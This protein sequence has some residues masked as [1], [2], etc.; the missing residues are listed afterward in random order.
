MTFIFPIHTTFQFLTIKRMVERMIQ[1]RILLFCLIAL[2]VSACSSFGPERISPDRF[3]YNDAIASSSN[4]QMLLNIVRLRYEDV[5]VFLTVSSV[6]TQYVY[7]SNA[8]VSGAAGLD[9]IIGSSVGGNAGIRYI[10]RPTITYSPLSGDDFAKQLLT[11]IPSDLIFSLIQSGWPAKELL[12][13]SLQRINSVVNTGDNSVAK[14]TD[15]TQQQFMRVIQLIIELGKRG[16][17]EVQRQNQNDN[18][19]PFL[20]FD[21]TDDAD[22]LRLIAEFKQIL[23]LDPERTRFQV[24]TRVVQRKPEEVTIR[25]RSMLTLMGFLAHG[26]AIPPA[27]AEI[28]TLPTQPTGSDN[29]RQTIPSPLQIHASVERPSDAFVSIRYQGHWFSIDR[30]DHA[31]KQAFGLLTYLFQLKS[32]EAPSAAPLLT[33]PTG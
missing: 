33:V 25:N 20:V 23:G 7:S 21:S 17:I 9:N 32:P 12:T 22:T 27:H 18:Y 19:E 3:N 5:P 14:Q 4:E 29:N 11:P 24:T 8:E 2:S 15:P 30:S 26:V 16:A 1:T 6:L 13:M 28:S 31:S 10:E